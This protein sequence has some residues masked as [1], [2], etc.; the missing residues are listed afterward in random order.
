MNSSQASSYFV[1]TLPT[2]Q[3]IYKE[4]SFWLSVFVLFPGFVLNCFMGCVFLRR[5]FW[6]KTTIGFYAVLHP[7]LSN[8]AVL[9]ALLNFFPYSL[10]KDLT[11]IGITVCRFIWFLRLFF[12]TGIQ[13]FQVLMT[14]DRA[15]SIVFPKRFVWLSKP[16]NLAILTT[17]IYFVIAGYAIIFQPFRHY[18]YVVNSTMEIK[19]TSCVVTDI[20]LYVNNISFLIIRSTGYMIILCANII[21][22][23]KLIKSKKNL[24]PRCIAGDRSLT[25]KE[26]AFA[27][28]LLTSNFV[29]IILISP[30]LIMLVIQIVF[31]FS[32]DVSKDVAS[33][34][35]TLYSITN[36]GNYVNEALLFYINLATNK[37]F[38]AELAR[39]ICPGTIRIA[40]STVSRIGK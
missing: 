31:S 25:A 23:R 6:R 37:V 19:A 18:I 40:D 33:F 2:L 39:L 32:D 4:L 38:R 29:T 13:Y 16:R 28:S 21:I 8:L 9:I 10:G 17:L 14:V 20:V 22:L 11:L 27:V 15:L 35:I 34:T 12:L 36:L 5:R 7:W 3:R 1:Q 24:Y 26:F 30:F